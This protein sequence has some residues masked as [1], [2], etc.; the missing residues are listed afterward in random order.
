[1]TTLQGES[2]LIFPCVDAQSVASVVADWT[3]IP[4]GR[5][6]KNEIE[7]VLKLADVLERRVIG[8][9]HALDIIAKRSP[10]Q[11]RPS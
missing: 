4:V 10:H 9:R 5:M 11:P 2:P 3:G 7:Q 6:A 8:Q 1:M